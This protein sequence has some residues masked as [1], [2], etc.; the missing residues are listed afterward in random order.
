MQQLLTCIDDLDHVVE[1][2]TETQSHG[3]VVVIGAINRPEVSDHAFRP[4]NISGCEFSHYT[5]IV[6]VT[7]VEYW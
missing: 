5:L 3:H 7:S 2:R 1:S 6:H 4:R